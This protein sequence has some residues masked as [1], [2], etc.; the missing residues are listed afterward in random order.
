MP[1]GRVSL[2]FAFDDLGERALKNIDPA[3]TAQCGAL[4]RIFDRAKTKVDKPL[5]VPQAFHCRPA[6][7]VD[8]IP[9]EGRP[10][11]I[12]GDRYWR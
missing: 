4:G 1:F 3:D 5:P 2:R 12:S 10:R 8:C 11:I 7:H 9:P 6:A